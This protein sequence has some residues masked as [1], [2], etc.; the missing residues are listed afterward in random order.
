MEKL[1]TGISTNIDFIKKMAEKGQEVNAEF[2]AETL[3]KQFDEIAEEDITMNMTNETFLAEVANS[4]EPTPVVTLNIDFNVSDSVDLFGKVA[5]DLQSE[6]TLND[7]T[8]EG[9]LKY[10]DDYTGFSGK[11]EEQSGN[12][13][14]LHVDTTSE[15]D[16]Y[17]E[18][19]NG[20]SGPVKLD[21]DK[22]IVLRIADK[23][24]QQV[25]VTAGNL[26]KLCSLEGLTLE[27]KEVEQ[28][29]QTEQTE[30]I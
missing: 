9:T 26:E 10:V 22:V 3:R 30:Q 5:S 12:Y 1:K 20:V 29:E 7:D 15:E 11:V 16:V 21:E 8:I 24:T 17:V 23:D 2:P 19:V 6:V 18:L 14:V 13:L 27:T 28:P 25:K 4:E